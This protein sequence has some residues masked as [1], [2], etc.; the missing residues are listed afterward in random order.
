M[1]QVRH[2][3]SDIELQLHSV[4]IGLRRPRHRSFYALCMKPA[5]DKA[6]SAI[7][8]LALSPLLLLLTVLIRL[9]S[10]GPA[11][12]KQL[13]IGKD[14]KEFTIYKFR[15][16][17]VHTPEQAVS[18]TSSSDPRITRIGRFLRKFSLDELP[19]LYN[20]LL[21]E[22]SFVGPRP[23]QK[24][25]VETCYTSYER[26]RLLVKPGLTGY[27]QISEDRK[28]PIHENLHHDFRYIREMSAL[29]DLRIVLRTVKLLFRSN[30][31]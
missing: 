3:A 14:G 15:T 13:R 21:G 18:P 1:D 8:L 29:T 27:W 31:C 11:L 9:D 10:A 20:I 2:G 28:K 12:F 22:M 17:Y 16:M 25:T 23:E 26:E 30:T 7:A 24:W 19:Q 6:V 5:V 4:S